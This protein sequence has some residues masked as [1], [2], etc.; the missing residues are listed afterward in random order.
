M[1]LAEVE[2]AKHG[3]GPLIIA[4][5]LA[6]IVEHKAQWAVRMVLLRPQVARDARYKVVPRQR[7]VVRHAERALLIR[8]DGAAQVVCRRLDWPGKVSVAGPAVALPSQPERRLGT[9]L[10]VSSQ[11]ETAC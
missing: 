7:E 3:D 11:S 5:L 9:L 2:A 4:Q 6:A 8:P 1:A 10:A